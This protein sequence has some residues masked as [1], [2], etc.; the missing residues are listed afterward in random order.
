MNWNPVKCKG[1]NA[2]PPARLPHA[3]KPVNCL[4][5]G[6]PVQPGQRKCEYCG[7]WFETPKTEQIILYADGEPFEIAERINDSITRD[8]RFNSIKI[9]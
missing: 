4:N 8:V 1:T 7:S 9:G 3:P 6:A 5:C 2:P